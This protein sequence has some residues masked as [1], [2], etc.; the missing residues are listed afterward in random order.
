[1]VA[2]PEEASAIGNLLIQARAD[3]QLGSLADVRSVVAASFPTVEYEPRRDDDERAELIAR[4]E[5]IA[6]T[7]V[8]V[9][10]Q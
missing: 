3:R 2:G 6:A 4:F 1:V 7:G 10:E 5:R 9:F 8:K